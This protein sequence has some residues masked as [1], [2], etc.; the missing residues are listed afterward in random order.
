MADDDK[1]C[2]DLGAAQ[3]DEED[4]N[5]IFNTA[6]KY[7][8]EVTVT[9]VDG[10]CHYGHKTGDTFGV[11]P[12]NHDGLCGSLYKLINGDV[13][14]PG[15]GGEVPWNKEKGVMTASCP[16]NNK[17]RIELRRIKQEKPISLKTR[18]DSKNMVGKG[19]PALDKFK[20]YLEVIGSEKNVRH[21][22]SAQIKA[23]QQE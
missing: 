8:Q 15:Y 11:T 2:I 16:E 1:P 7:Y 23:F 14:T 6:N 22:N 9:G 4:I 12:R 13:L 19:Y 21:N 3:F 10:E 17:V 18:T 5:F 20:I